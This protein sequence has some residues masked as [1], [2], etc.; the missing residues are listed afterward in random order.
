MVVSEAQ[1][2]ERLATSANKL[3]IDEAI[4]HE[5]RI[6]LHAEVVNDESHVS[7]A[8]YSFL[9][10]V[11]DEIK[12]PTDKFAAFRA[13]C[14]LPLAT[15]ATVSMIQDEY[16]KIFTAN[17][18]FF[19]CLILDESLKEIFMDYLKEVI[20]IRDLFKND[21]FDTWKTHPNTILLIDLPARQT[22]LWPQPY[23][24]KIP[25]ESVH[26]IEV[27]DNPDGTD[28][29]GL[30]IY[31]A[32]DRYDEATSRWIRQYVVVDDV[33]YQLWQEAFTETVGEKRYDPVRVVYHNLKYTP[34]TFMTSAKLY[35][36]NPIARKVPI[37]A[38]LSD[39]DNLQWLTTAKRVL[40]TYAPFPI[41]T[42]PADDENCTNPDCHG[43]TIEKYSLLVGEVSSY[44]CPICSKK[45]DRSLVGPGSVWEQR[46]PKI[47]DEPWI[48][49]AVTFTNP[50]VESLEYLQGEIDKQ[51]WKIYENNVG[52]TGE[53][54]PKQAVNEFQVQHSENGK[55]NVFL[56]IAK[57][58]EL[59]QKFSVDTMGRLMFGAFYVSCDLS[60]GTQFLLYSVKDLSEQYT[61]FKESG[62]PQ[63]MVS[64]KRQMLLQ[65]E[66]RNNPYLI[67]RA[68]ILNLLEPWPDFSIAEVITMQYNQLFPDAFDLKCFFSQ[69]VDIFEVENGDIVEWGSEIEFRQKILK[70]KQIFKDYGKKETSGRKQLPEPDKKAPVN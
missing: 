22:T 7:P 3:W 14:K 53:V 39:L 43:G 41:A 68:T 34:A 20:K 17:D 66:H 54:L 65:T 60:Y 23:V 19:D 69:I 8:F 55:E 45:K 15:N 18:S 26:D 62:L 47:K 36:T 4:A 48:P 52:D 49:E 32:V 21:I 46:M 63:F 30:L 31:K 6:R 29:I 33:S 67:Q 64:Q 61:S 35:K 2:R 40:E 11:R 16:E 58:M 51:E 10:W 9:A 50:A 70:L 59:T 1:V 5:Q 25:L 13:L 37:S 27:E 12:L 57:D 44:P 42:V 38:S 56:R 28:K 24:N